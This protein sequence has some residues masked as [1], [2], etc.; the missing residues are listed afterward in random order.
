MKAIAKLKFL[1][2]VNILHCLVYYWLLW[3]AHGCVL[4]RAFYIYV[5]QTLCLLLTQYT[6]YHSLAWPMLL[7]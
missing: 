1:Y 7:F 5:G 4:P 2:K 6:M 3:P